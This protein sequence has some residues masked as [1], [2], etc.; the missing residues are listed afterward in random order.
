MT[1]SGLF[2]IPLHPG[3][4]E[5]STCG[6]CGI[7]GEIVP[8]INACEKVESHKVHKW[9]LQ[10]LV[11]VAEDDISLLKCPYCRE[12]VLFSLSKLLS[13]QQEHGLQIPERGITA[14]SQALLR[15]SMVQNLPKGNKLG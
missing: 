14:M 2:H 3:Q 7:R 6:I 1:A 4:D 15:R 5:S 10:E 8:N 9:C 13:F 11:D 12:G